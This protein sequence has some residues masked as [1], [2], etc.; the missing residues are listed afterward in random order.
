MLSGALPQRIEEEVKQQRA[1]TTSK[2]RLISTVWSVI[3]SAFRD[4]RVINFLIA[5]LGVA[6]APR[7]FV[8][9]RHLAGRIWGSTQLSS[10][11]TFFL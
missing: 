8:S 4:A 7:C 6:L 11:T 5:A 3:R 1:A 10:C 9:R 2:S